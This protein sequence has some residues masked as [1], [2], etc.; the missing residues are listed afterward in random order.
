LRA[1]EHDMFV[2]SYFFA[3]MLGS[4]WYKEVVLSSLGVHIDSKSGMIQKQQSHSQQYSKWST[5]KQ[6]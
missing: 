1:I 5:L 4:F 2:S 6:I 3:A